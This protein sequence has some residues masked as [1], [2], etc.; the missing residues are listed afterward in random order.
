M[1]A[2][3]GREAMKNLKGDL[4]GV[5]FLDMGTPVMNGIELTASLKAHPTY[6]KV[7]FLR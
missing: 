1:L 2:E 6:K 3:S 4:P 5:V 7:Q